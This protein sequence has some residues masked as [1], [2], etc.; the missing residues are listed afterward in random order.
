YYLTR[1]ER[2]ILENHAPDM[3]ESCHK[4][5]FRL[6]E[7]GVGDGEKTK[8]LLRHF[9]SAS[10]QFDYTPVD[11]CQDALAGLT[12]SLEKHLGRH[13]LRV[14][15]VVAEYFEALSLLNRHDAHTMVLFLGSNIGNLRPDES[16]RFLERV[17]RTLVPGD[18]L[19]I[20]FDLKKD[21]ALLL[22]AYNDAQGVTREFNFNLLDRINRELGGRFD[23]T[24][25]Q[26]YGPYNVA[27][28]RMESWLV[29]LVDQRVVVRG[30]G[31]VFKFAR[32]EGIHVE[33]S[34][35]YTV[36]QIECMARASGFE[37]RRNFVDRQGWFVDSL[38]EAIPW[39]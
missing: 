13:E 7:L 5:P 23:R 36:E 39:C 2:E 10:L 4:Q 34:Y 25:F 30:L 14:H 19:L 29:S 31:R 20:G 12:R 32:G 9:L 28:G 1:A 26:H 33:C 17:R 37:V 22:R 3:A 15:G 11:I 6:V 27:C 35:K 24:L 8:I 16:R 38:W 21:P 18:R